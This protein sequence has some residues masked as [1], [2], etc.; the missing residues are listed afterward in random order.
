MSNKEEILDYLKKL[1]PSLQ[2]EGIGRLGLFGSHARGEATKESDLDIVYESSQQ[3]L[4]KHHGWNACVYLDRELRNKVA[5]R[6]G[7]QVDLFD[8]N[9][10]SPFKDTI[11]K[12]ALYV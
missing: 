3:F 6:F 1:K 9:S 2:S 11:V 5:D 12:E 8:I 7:L 10:H 4:E